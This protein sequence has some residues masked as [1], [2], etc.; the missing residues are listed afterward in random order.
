MKPDE[1][2]YAAF[3]P[4]WDKATDHDW[5]AN[6]PESIRQEEALDGEGFIHQLPPVRMIRRI[7]APLAPL[8]DRDANR[9]DGEDNHKAG[10]PMSPPKRTAHCLFDAMAAFSSRMSSRYSSLK[11]RKSSFGRKRVSVCSR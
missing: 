11:S 7:L 2:L 4:A 3:H 6:V 10:E 8:L 9:E 1:L 5:R